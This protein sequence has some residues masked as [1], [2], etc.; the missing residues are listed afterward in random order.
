VVFRYT[1]IEPISEKVLHKEFE[2]PTGCVSLTIEINCRSSPSIK[3]PL[4]ILQLIFL[5]PV[6]AAQYKYVYCIVWKTQGIIRY[7][8]LENG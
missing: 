1:F 7:I 4:N 8:K 3:S 2:I 6:I 5:V